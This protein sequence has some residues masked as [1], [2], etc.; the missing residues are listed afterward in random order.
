MVEFSIYLLNSIHLSFM[1][2]QSL[3]GSFYFYDCYT[4]VLVYCSVKTK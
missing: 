2:W 1:I 3:V 4:F